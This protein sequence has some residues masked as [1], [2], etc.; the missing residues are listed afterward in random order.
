MR[1][2]NPPTAGRIHI[3]GEWVMDADQAK[4]DLRQSRR[5][6][7][8]LVIQKANLIPFL[9]A[10][11]NMQV[12]LKINDASLRVA[13]QRSLEL[14]DYLGF[15]DRGRATCRMCFP[16]DSNNALPWTARLPTGRA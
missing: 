6:H 1:L 7:L 15:A 10:V 3:G 8:G 9:S 16:A 4:V 12:A 14:L 5:C 11:E 13:R 2:N